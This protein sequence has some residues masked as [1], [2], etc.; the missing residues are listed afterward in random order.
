MENVKDFNLEK[1]RMELFQL[2]RDNPELLEIQDDLNKKLMSMENQDAKCFY[3][4]TE[5]FDKLDELVVE[6]Q[7][8]QNKLNDR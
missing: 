2:L 7:R 4:M 6:L 1:V 8:L 5:C 3:L